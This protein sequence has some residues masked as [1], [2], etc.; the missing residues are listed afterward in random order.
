MQKIGIN[1]RPI[2][3]AS[4]ISDVA[5]MIYVLSYFY[6]MFFV[7]DTDAHFLTDFFVRFNPMTLGTYFVGLVMLLHMVAFKNVI[8]RC[9][10]ATIYGFTMIVSLVAIMGMTSWSDLIIYIPH[11]I[12]ISAAFVVLHRQHN[13]FPEETNHKDEKCKSGNQ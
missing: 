1:T 3:I 4:L 5:M 7:E 9:L 6:W 2:Q 12:I 11:L 8:G 13:H 10:L